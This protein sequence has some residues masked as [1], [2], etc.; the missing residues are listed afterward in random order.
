MKKLVFSLLLILVSISSINAQ[1]T[2]DVDNLTYRVDYGNRYLYLTGCMEPVTNL[3]I[4]ET[5]TYKD[6]EYT[7]VG[8]DYNAF[9]NNTELTSLSIPKTV[10]T[11]EADLSNTSLY[12][13]ESK[14]TDG[15]LYIDNCLIAGKED[16]DGICKI[17]EGTR[18]ISAYA[19]QGS[20]ASGFEIPESVISIG[21]DAFT[22]SKFYNT[23]SN[24]TGMS[25]YLNNCLLTCLDSKEE[26]LVKEDTRLIADAAFSYGRVKNCTIPQSVKYIGNSA[27]TNSSIINIKLSEGLEYIGEKAFANC[28]SLEKFTF[29][30]SV[31][32]IG[33]G[34]FD[35][36]L[37]LN[38]I[39]LPEGLTTISDRMFAMTGLTTY[40]I[41]EGITR[42]G[43][44]LFA[45]CQNLTSVTIPATVNTIC[46]SFSYAYTIKTINNKALKPQALEENT[47]LA[48]DLKNLTLNV[49][50][51]ALEAYKQADIWKDFGSINILSSIKPVSALDDIYF[52]NK[53]VN[54]INGKYITIYN[55]NGGIVYTGNDKYITLTSGI[56]IIVC[57]NKSMKI[58]L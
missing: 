20:T 22:D 43:N 26:Y 35:G 11:I 31:Q 3:V 24:W 44:E 12:A 15:V 51:S 42:L 16:F 48:V 56:Y 13:D 54:N 6:E 19:F 37:K 40:E 30:Q 21:K 46:T 47:F 45:F 1:S 32:V 10:R 29:P 27:F 23:S 8:I 52:L 57:G 7:V 34:C 41:P 9:S 50:E 5:V 2:I 25:I 33:S 58:S 14:W 49:E 36:C 38:S 17:K 4:P 18:V 28:S 39:E 53:K 55:S